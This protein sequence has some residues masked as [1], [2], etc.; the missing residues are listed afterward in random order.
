[1]V[2]RM[3]GWTLEH[4]DWVNMLCGVNWSYE[5]MN[6]L[7]RTGR[8]ELYDFREQTGIFK[9]RRELI[10]RMGVQEIFEIYKEATRT[11]FQEEEEERRVEREEFEWS[12]HFEIIDRDTV[13]FSIGRRYTEEE[14]QLTKLKE[15]LIKEIGFDLEKYIG[16]ILDY[17]TIDKMNKELSKLIQ[18][19]ENK[20][21]MRIEEYIKQS[22]N[23]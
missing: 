4:E 11:K 18:E 21:R 12:P 6:W 7:D 14:R 19:F 15:R 22:S 20:K 23:R 10:E 8:K 2:E 17:K 9:W 5:L 1:M 16:N 13:V 3:A